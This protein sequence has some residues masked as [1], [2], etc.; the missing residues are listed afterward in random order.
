[1]GKTAVRSRLLS[2][3]EAAA[4]LG[5][6]ERWMWDVVSRREIPTVCL[7]RRRLFRPSDLDAY[8]ERHVEASDREFREAVAAIIDRGGA[9]V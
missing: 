6:S 7:G 9:P 2:V 3:P 1:V 5:M 8:V 4:R